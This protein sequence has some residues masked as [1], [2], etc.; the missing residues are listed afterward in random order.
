M[1]L[2]FGVV[3]CGALLT[4]CAS[5][6]TGRAVAGAVP[7]SVTT[8]TPARQMTGPARQMDLC[9]LISWSDLGYPGTDNAAGPTETDTV[10]GAL[11]SCVW[12]SQQFH[13]G[14]TP[15]PE[16]SCNNDDNSG[17]LSGSLSCVGDDAQQL[18]DIE[19]NSTWVTV[20]IAYLAG[21]PVPTAWSYVDGGHI[22]YLD[23]TGSTCAAHTSWDHATLGVADTDDSKAFGSPCDEVR[24]VVARL[25]ERE[26]RATS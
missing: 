3:L 4:G 26:P 21:R 2:I 6:M 18:A 8:T 17:D 12:K 1:K 15:P 10:D 23:Q 19:N 7:P 9:S 20:T 13:A 11:A 25:V 16:P 22:V 5:T 24:K 14:Y